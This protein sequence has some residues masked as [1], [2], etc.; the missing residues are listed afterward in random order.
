[1]LE[2]SRIG[3]GSALL[4]SMVYFLVDG[5]A[6][7]L[8]AGERLGECGSSGCVI[9]SYQIQWLGLRNAACCKAGA[10]ISLRSCLGC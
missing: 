4:L 9:A 10:N 3:Q 8:T 6:S 7:V 1:M 5:S 2:V